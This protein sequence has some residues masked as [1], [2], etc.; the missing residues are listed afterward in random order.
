M[1]TLTK[2][3]SKRYSKVRTRNKEE[4]EGISGAK[5]AEDNAEEETKA[6]KRLGRDQPEAGDA[7]EEETNKAEDGMNSDELWLST[8]PRR[9]HPL[10][11]ILAPSR[12]Y[13]LGPSEDTRWIEQQNSV[14]FKMWPVFLSVIIDLFVNAYTEPV[15]S[16]KRTVHALVFR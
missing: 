3:I 9:R 10:G 11:F 5:N 13:A 8:L 2:W 4:L 1:R 12:A 16:T 7:Q 6:G 15:Y 14:M